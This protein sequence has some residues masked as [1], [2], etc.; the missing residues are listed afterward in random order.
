[1]T[2]WDPNEVDKDGDWYI[3]PREQEHIL[4]SELAHFPP[5]TKKKVGRRYRELIK[6]W[7]HDTARYKYGDLI[8]EASVYMSETHSDPDKAHSLYFQ[9]NKDANPEDFKY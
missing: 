6:A 9:R 1:V 7:R 5:L 4:L 8:K 2:Q 3:T